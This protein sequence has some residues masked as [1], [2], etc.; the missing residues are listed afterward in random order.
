MKALFSFCYRETLFF[1]DNDVVVGLCWD[2]IA[3]FF[4]LLFSDA[5]AEPAASGF[6]AEDQ[7]TK[8][9]PEIAE[10][11][12]GDVQSTLHGTALLAGRGGGLVPTS[13]GTIFGGRVT[14]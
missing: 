14:F 13:R 11:A 3:P 5:A 1:C 10:G 7:R 6:E 9:T 2:E 8:A 12:D 4:T